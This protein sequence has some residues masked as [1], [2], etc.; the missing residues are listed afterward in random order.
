MKS[1]YATLEKHMTVSQAL[2]ALRSEAPDAE[3][4]YNAYVI[5]GQRKLLGVISLRALILANPENLIDELIVQ[6]PV[7]C[8]VTDKQEKVAKKIPRYDLIALPILDE[9]KA[10]VGIVTHDDAL[11]VERKEATEDFHLAAG[12]ESTLGNLKEA[13]IALL[14]RKRVF[15]LMLLIFGNLFSGAGIAHFEDIIAA[16]IGL[17]C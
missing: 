7:Y 3:T 11:D 16:N 6:K 5:D 12:V 17:V 9:N 8:K 2:D 14:Y 10:I 4:I 13:S 1:D 15:W